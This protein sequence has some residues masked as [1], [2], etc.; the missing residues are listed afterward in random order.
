MKMQLV[1]NQSS[2]VGL[3]VK[4][5]PARPRQLIAHKLTAPCLAAQ[6][7]YLDFS[8]GSFGH[9][10]RIP[11]RAAA[12]GT[13]GTTSA[14]TAPQGIYANIDFR[15]NVKDICELTVF[16]SLGKIAYLAKN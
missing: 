9:G 12:S 10:T 2:N 1:C 7:K 4:P 3:H 8:V 11:R 14:E 16:G 13:N 6:N 5:S 15:F